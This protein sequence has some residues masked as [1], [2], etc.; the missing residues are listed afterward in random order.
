MTKSLGIIHNLTPPASVQGL[1]NDRC[2]NRAL[3]IPS[4][5]EP[6]RNADIASK[7]ST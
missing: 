6:D 3:Y 7:G 5:D 1:A 4:S 2:D